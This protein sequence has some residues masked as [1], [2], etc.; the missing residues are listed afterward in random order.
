M[1][2]STLF[3]RKPSLVKAGSGKGEKQVFH[4][5]SNFADVIMYRGLPPGVEHRDSRVTLGNPNTT[6]HEIKTYIIVASTSDEPTQ[7][8]RRL[9]RVR[10]TWTCGR[11]A[12][13]AGWTR[14]DWRAP[15]APTHLRDVCFWSGSG[16]HRFRFR[17]RRP[18][19]G[20]EIPCTFPSRDLSDRRSH[21]PRPR[22]GPGSLET[23]IIDKLI[24]KK[25]SKCL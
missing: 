6:Q 22:S 24:E 25:K 23:Q 12:V 19:L 7:V 13:A 21:R 5:A 3:K 14:S 20:D 2:N 10:G 15:A 8:T 16:C 11:T 9:P 18:S 17:R 1:A 4:Q